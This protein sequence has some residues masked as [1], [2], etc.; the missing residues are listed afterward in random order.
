M[1]RAVR[2]LTAATESISH[3]LELRTIQSVTQ[4]RLMKPLVMCLHGKTSS[5]HRKD[6]ADA[7]PQPAELEY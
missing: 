5:V 1:T 6:A 2:R 7:A 3:Q 4:R